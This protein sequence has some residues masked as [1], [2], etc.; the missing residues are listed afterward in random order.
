MLTFSVGD[1]HGCLREFQVLLDLIERYAAGQEHRIITIGDYIDRGPNSKGVLDLLMDRPEIITLMGN[2]ERMLLDAAA[3]DNSF[4]FMINGGAATCDS[5]GVLDAG[6]IPYKYLAFLRSLEL[7]VNDGQ[8]LFVH[9]GI[10]PA[11]TLEQQVEEDILWIRE[12]FLLCTF[13]F[14]TYI[15]HGH[16]PVQNVEIRPNR[17]NLDTGCVFGG[18]LS[19]A[20]FDDTQV[21]PIDVI[22]VPFGTKTG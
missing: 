18:A 13:P 20:V 21:K 9:A 12:N 7:A 22:R 5:F 19:A 8:R 14:E 10:N 2:H 6:M 16:T 11:R 1:I 3:G 4:L 17:T 15:V